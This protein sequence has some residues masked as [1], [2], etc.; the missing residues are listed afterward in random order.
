MI[1]MP[2]S[3]R[4]IKVHFKPHE[5]HYRIICSWA[6][7][8][9]CSDYWKISSGIETFVDKGNYYESE[10]TSGSIYRLNK[11]CEHSSAL[12]MQIYLDYYGKSKDTEDSVFDMITLDD[13]L[14]EKYNDIDQKQNP[15]T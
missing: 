15:D 6:G 5:L 7:G 11:N 10:Q 4:I 1:Y 13:F 2:D 12:I 8:Y 9:A 3:W 14:K